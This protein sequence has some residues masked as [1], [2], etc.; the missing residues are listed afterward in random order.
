MILL[1]DSL[2]YQSFVY[3]SFVWEIHVRYININNNSDHTLA[4]LCQI[5][6]LLKDS[7]A[8]FKDD[9]FMQNTDS[10]FNILLR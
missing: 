10:H 2:K 4:S 7:P 8:V 6:G 1:S 9:K 3:G 5:Q